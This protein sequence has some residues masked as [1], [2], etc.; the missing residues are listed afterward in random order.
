[1]ATKES[2]RKKESMR[3]ILNRLLRSGNRDLIFDN[4]LVKRITGT[5]FSNQFD[6]T[7]FDSSE[8][9]PEFLREED[10]FII[11]LGKGRHQFIK[12][13]KL[14]YHKFETISSSNVREWEY[15]PA[16]LNGVDDS[17]AAVLSLA[18]NQQILQHFLFN[19]RTVVPK[20]HLPRRTK[21]TFDYRIGSK[22]ISVGGLQ[23]EKDLVTEHQGTIVIFE[24]KNGDRKDF[25]IGQLYNP[26][27]YLDNLIQQGEIK[28]VREIR[29]VYILRIPDRESGKTMLRLYEYNFSDKSRLDSIA[30]IKGI[31]YNLQEVV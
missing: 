29:L 20:I 14:G 26:Y 6:A 11:H 15:K 27:R 30:F 17:E 8:L 7:K 23:I 31:Q 13:I 18:F 5:D 21:A 4:S 28:D 24:A 22:L 19:D 1:M 9:L 3:L 16:I 25:L 2:G 10:Y 12:G